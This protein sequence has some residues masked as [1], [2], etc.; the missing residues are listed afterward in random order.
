M[1]T[2]AIRTFRLEIRL[3]PRQAA[4]PALRAGNNPGRSRASTRCGE[5]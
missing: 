2:N 5:T 4:E 3:R 1:L